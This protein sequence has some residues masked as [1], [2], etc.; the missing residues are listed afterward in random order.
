MLSMLAQVVRLLGVLFSSFCS[1]LS[2]E[3]KFPYFHKLHFIKN[4]RIYLCV[5]STA[6]RE[7]E[8]QK[9]CFSCWRREPPSLRGCPWEG[10]LS[11]FWHRTGGC[12]HPLVWV[13]LLTEPRSDILSALLYAWLRTRPRPS[14]WPRSPHRNKEENGTKWPLGVLRLRSGGFWKIIA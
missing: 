13:D 10:D 7:T 14:L 1:Y 8:T 5:C 4:N 6:I 12:Y 9:H 2:P 3:K 11:V